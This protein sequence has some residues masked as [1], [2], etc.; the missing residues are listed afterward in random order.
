MFDYS[1]HKDENQNISKYWRKNPKSIEK[2]QFVHHFLPKEDKR[3][4][5]DFLEN[6]AI[7]IYCVL[8]LIVTA[9]FR[10]IPKVAPGVLGYASDINITDLLKYT[11]KKR[12]EN[13][14]SG[15]RLNDKLSAA[16][17]NKAKDMFEDGYW[18]HVAPDG[19]EPWDFIVGENYEY[20]Y[21]GENLAK[22][23][24]T[25]KEV[26]EAWFKS[27]SHKSNLIGANYDE[28][29]FAVVNGVMNGY[30]TTLV[31]QMFGKPRQPSMLAS[32]GEEVVN[33]GRNTVSASEEEP[34][35]NLG[36]SEVRSDTSVSDQP[37]GNDSRLSEP[38]P[39]GS[40]INNFIDV[41]LA[42]KTISLVVGGFVVSLLLIDILY[43]RK[44]GIR[45]LTGLTLAHM[46]ILLVV[47]VSIWLV[48]RPGL[49]V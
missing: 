31:V 21:A 23:F 49:I 32:V 45:K 37:V 20:I 46:A 7:L 2:Y 19:T 47:I 1:K 35:S 27:P 41:T 29:G 17:Q 26:V 42:T 9:I 3:K 43:S 13:G 40:P 10:V 14:V 28:V 15:L 48:F 38:I 18:A 36:E 11:N 8:I 12:E 39:S 44:K 30:E 16:A 5:A 4:R 25:S 6:K 22:N 33:I 34:S 24:S